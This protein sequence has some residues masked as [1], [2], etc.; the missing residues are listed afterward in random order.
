MS[1]SGGAKKKE[2]AT[3]PGE[4]KGGMTGSD[5]TDS[6]EDEIYAKK[7][8]GARDE[9]KEKI[10]KKLTKNKKLTFRSQFYITKF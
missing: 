9:E 2:K 4:G 1:S 6:A 8:L 7:I 3:R 10:Q 5:D